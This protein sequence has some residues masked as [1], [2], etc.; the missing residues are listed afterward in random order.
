MRP[1]VPAA[2]I[3]YVKS[4]PEDERVEIEMLLSDVEEGNIRWVISH[5]G[6][7]APKWNVTIRGTGSSVRTVLGGGIHKSLRMAFLLAMIGAFEEHDRRLRLIE[8]QRVKR[9][10]DT[11]RELYVSGIKSLNA[12]KEVL[13]AEWPEERDGSDR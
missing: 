6:L 1:N 11:T 3:E 2:V 4:L 13:D 10:R 7:V 9:Q 12:L 8:S 5:D